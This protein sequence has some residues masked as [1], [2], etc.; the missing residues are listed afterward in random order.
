[1]NAVAR[2]IRG[3]AFSLG[4]R[5]GP[6]PLDDLIQPEGKEHYDRT[7][8]LVTEHGW[9]CIYVGDHA[10]ETGNFGYTVGLSGKGL[11]EL[12]F[13]IDESDIAM[14]M[15][16]A[17]ATRLVEHG[18]GVPDGFAPFPGQQLRLRNIYPVEFY[19]KCV[20][21]G[22]WAIEHDA[23]AGATGMQ[24]VLAEADGSFPRD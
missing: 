17:I 18:P 11:P 8:A 20:M 13:V 21:A 22:I 9:A 2:W 6:P 7:C 19:R 10:N 3:K 12:L 1:M 14:A 15:L 16:N 23:M 4:L 5:K 24:V